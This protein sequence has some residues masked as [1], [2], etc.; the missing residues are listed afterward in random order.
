M[1]NL[2]KIAVIGAGLAGVSCAKILTEFAEVT[3][4]EK[5][6]GTGGRMSARRREKYDFDH[7]AQFFT[8]R[9]KS[10]QAE[11]D[12]AV[13]AKKVREWMPKVVNLELGAKPFKREWFEP[14]YCGLNGMNS[15]AKHL[16]V[17]LNIV[18]ETKVERLKLESGSWF[19]IDE[20]EKSTGPYD[21]VISAVPAPQ[22]IDLMPRSFVAKN[23]FE[24]A[25][26]T[27]CF[28]MMLGFENPVSLNFQAAVLTHPVLAW[29]SAR[30]SSSLLIHSR[31]DWASEHIDADPQ[32]VESTMYKA[33]MELLPD[34]DSQPSHR[35]LHR[36][37]YAK[38]EHT[39]GHDYF[40]DSDKQIAAIG[41]WC[42]G[43][44]VEDAFVSG[45]E[46]A[47]KLKTELG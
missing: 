29:L 33:F 28:A 36:W 34:I 42:R 23:K 3:L 19:L 40:L 21:W 39:L 8:A 6:R 22:A 24:E 46:L 5:S 30:D 11:I 32:W 43:G 37:R 41:D 14:H 45:Y 7:G 25:Q 2:P 4:F 35:D 26:F 1:T 27:S 17:D 16:A 10:F 31:N 44:R 9:S 20:N 18:H 13:R 12:S 15:L 38:C 47:Q